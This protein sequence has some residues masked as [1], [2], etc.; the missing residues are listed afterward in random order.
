MKGQLVSSFPV[1]EFNRNGLIGIGMAAVQE[2]SYS[3]G[4]ALYHWHC[5]YYTSG[6]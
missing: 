2:D 1:Q 5:T 6:S 4:L 3:L